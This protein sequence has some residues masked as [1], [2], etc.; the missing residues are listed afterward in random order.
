MNTY[1]C[2]KV[3][4]AVPCKMV[5][6]CP[7]PDG[8]P[9]PEVKDCVDPADGW[10]SEHPKIMD[11][12]LYTD[13]N[14]NQYT[15][16]MS[17]TDFELMCKPA[18]CMAFG[19]AIEAMKHGERV[20]RHRWNGTGMYVFLAHEPD[21]VTDADISEFD[22]QEVEVCDVLVMKTAQNAFQLGWLASQADMLAEDWYIVE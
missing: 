19:D 4:H 13:E 22:Q 12:Y 10:I 3:I 8:L 18:D 5:N 2:T 6:G 16:F 17:A 1:I 11:G 9:L 15:Q 21:F 7:W 20:S 14:N